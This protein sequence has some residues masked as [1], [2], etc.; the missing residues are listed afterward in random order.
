[1]STTPPDLPAARTCANCACFGRMAADGSMVET[2][3]D[4]T[5]VCRRNPPGASRQRVEVPLVD[6]A[7]KLPVVD[8]GRPRLVAQQV[9]V[10]GYPAT[11]P[12]ATCFDGWRPL[13]T[14][15]GVRWEA[16]RMLEAFQPWMEKALVQSGVSAKQARELGQAMI[17]GVLPPRTQ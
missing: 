9:I 5:P 4:T 16:Q 2:E 10:I 12:Q 3:T 14:S 1:M 11:A 17:T 7:T 13:G 6:P 8:R 15:P